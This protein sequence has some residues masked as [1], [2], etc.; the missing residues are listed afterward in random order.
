MTAGI[1]LVA[2][3]PKRPPP[4]WKV[5]V[6]VHSVRVLA[7]IGG[8]PIWVD[9]FDDPQRGASRE[10]AVRESA[11][12]GSAGGLI[13]VDH[14]DDQRSRRLIEVAD[15]HGG[16]R[17]SLRRATDH[18]CSASKRITRRSG[19]ATARRRNAAGGYH[20]PRQPRAREAPNQHPTR[21]RRQM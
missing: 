6:E 10:R 19:R 17:P 16:D 8:H 11:C 20:E 3:P 21:L 9:A 15:R 18:E 7:A 1:L 4:P 14:A 2:A 12:N 5:A 13:A